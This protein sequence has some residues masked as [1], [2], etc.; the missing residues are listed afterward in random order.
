MFKGLF[1]KAIGSSGTPWNTRS[2]QPVTLHHS[3]A[4]G[5]TL[6]SKLGVNG[7]ANPLAAARALDWQTVMKASTQYEGFSYRYPGS[8]MEGYWDVTID[9]EPIDFR[10]PAPFM[11]KQPSEIFA[12]GEQNAVPMMLGGN[13]GEVMN[14]GWIIFPETIPTYVE[15]FEGAAKAHQKSY[16]YIFDQMPV[17]LRK[18]PPGTW[19]AT[20]GMDVPYVFG[21]LDL[22]TTWTLTDADRY[23]SEAMMSMFTQFAKTGDPNVQGYVHWPQYEAADKFLFIHD[24]LVIKTPFSQIGPGE[25]NPQE[26]GK[27]RP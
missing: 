21:A 2:A 7:T 16:A 12:A 9:Y 1:H 4:R 6:F 15:I 17:N 24:G 10:S 8:E 22:Q 5:I 20:H 13:L 11:P 19:A 3:H 14:V 25:Y 23:V 18:P 26:P 27:Y